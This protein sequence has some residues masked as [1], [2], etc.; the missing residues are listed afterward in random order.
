MSKLWTSSL[1]LCGSLKS[2]YQVCAANIGHESGNA[3]KNAVTGRLCVLLL[4]TSLITS[5]WLFSHLSTKPR[6]TLSRDI[7]LAL[8]GNS[9][10]KNTFLGYKN[11]QKCGK[12]SDQKCE[13]FSWYFFKILLPLLTNS[14]EAI[15]NWREG[16]GNRVTYNMWSFCRNRNR[17]IRCSWRNKAR[18]Q[19][20]HSIGI[21]PASCPPHLLTTWWKDLSFVQNK[22]A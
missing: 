18:A 6:F 22:T 5:F 15:H 19:T 14:S 3:F 7:L 12:S 13:K 21:L 1:L 17:F 20:E 9:K 11:L 8:L 4:C 2:G 16:S 10:K